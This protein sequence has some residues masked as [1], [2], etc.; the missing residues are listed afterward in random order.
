MQFVLRRTKGL[1]V[2]ERDV[3]AVASLE[4]VRI[5]DRTHKMLLLDGDAAQLEAFV[6][7]HPGWLLVEVKEYVL[8]EPK[9]EKINEAPSELSRRDT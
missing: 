5:H 7:E 6:N 9:R 2:D 3:D 4:G 1:T 8:P